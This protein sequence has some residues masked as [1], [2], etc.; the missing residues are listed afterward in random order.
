MVMNR[1]IP[2]EFVMHAIECSLPAGKKGADMM[3]KISI[4]SL[5]HMKICA[6]SESKTFA[7]MLKVI[8]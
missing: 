8:K 3:K 7:E 1:P 2:P 5:Q 4:L 6:D